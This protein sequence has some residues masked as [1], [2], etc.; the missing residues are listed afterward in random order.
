MQA[1]ALAQNGEVHVVCT[2][3]YFSEFGRVFVIDP[4]AVAVVDSLDIGGSPGFIAINGAGTAYLS[5]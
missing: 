5:D 4:V 1:L 3:N 2:G